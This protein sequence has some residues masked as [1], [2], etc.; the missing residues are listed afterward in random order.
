MSCPTLR[1]LESRRS[2]ARSWERRRTAPLHRSALP[3]SGLGPRAIPSQNTLQR[4]VGIGERRRLDS[5]TQPGPRGAEAILAE[6]LAQ[7]THMVVADRDRGRTV[8]L[9]RASAR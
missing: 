4:V 8:Q 5:E 6:K 2:E 3:G 7:P 1:R 9:R